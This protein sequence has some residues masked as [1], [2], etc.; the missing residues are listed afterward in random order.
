MRRV[1]LLVAVVFI[2]I[3]AAAS[4]AS[5]A[6]SNKFAAS[7]RGAAE[8]PPVATAA[9]GKAQFKV[10]VTGS[11]PTAITYVIKGSNIDKVIAGH[12]HLGK[13]G[14]EGPIVVSLV[15]PSACQFTGTAF[16][17]TGTIRKA[18]LQGPFAGRSLNALVQRM[19]TGGTYVNIHTRDFPDGEMRGQIRVVP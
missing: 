13:V 1:S 7:L 15:R 19:R 2:S 14:Q 18:N 5:S 3:L 9:T 4:T 12:I 11:T 8:V 10:L 17:C 16:T 6:P